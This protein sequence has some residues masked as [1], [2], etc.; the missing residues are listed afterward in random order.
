MGLRVYGLILQ[1]KLKFN[2]LP[3][4]LGKG[5]LFPEFTSRCW[6]SENVRRPNFG[7]ITDDFSSPKTKITRVVALRKFEKALILK[8]PGGN[9]EQRDVKVSNLHGH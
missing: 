3:K 4:I 1:L 8:C 9:P 5:M 7:S 6:V 2:Q